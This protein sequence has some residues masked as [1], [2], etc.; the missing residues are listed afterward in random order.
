[1][2]K[3]SSEHKTKMRICDSMVTDAGVTIPLITGQTGVAGVMSQNGYAYPLNFWTDVLSR[4]EVIRLIDSKECRGTVEHPESDDEFMCTSYENTSHIVTKAWVQ[5][6][7]PFATFA[8][9]NNP[10]GNA[11]KALIDVGAPVGVSTRGMGQFGHTELGNT[12][13]PEDYMFITWDIVKAP[14]FSELRMHCAPVT[15]SLLE[16]PTFKALAEMHHLKDSAYKGYNK[17][18]LIHEMG[19]AI[20]DLQKKFDILKGL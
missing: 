1:M 18:N 5:N 13:M 11:I 14:N 8:L 6:N 17:E 16:S 4:Q 3:I 7:Q 15:D 10:K 9:L 12:V 19:M 20:A 2:Y